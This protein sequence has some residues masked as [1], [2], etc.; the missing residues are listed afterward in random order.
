LALSPQGRRGRATLA[1][2]LVR[3]RYSMNRVLDD[4]TAVYTLVVPAS[5]SAA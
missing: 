3:R 2:D 5:G 4:V 1:L